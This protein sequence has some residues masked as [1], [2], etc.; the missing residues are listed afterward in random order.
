[1]VVISA[2]VVLIVSAGFGLP[3]WRTAVVLP[4]FARIALCA[5][6]ML[7]GYDLGA[8]PQVFA[9]WEERLLR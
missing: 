7:P 8:V 9:S 1:L 4:V 6:L 5:V 2:L 3:L